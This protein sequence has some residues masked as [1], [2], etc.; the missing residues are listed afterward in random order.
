M[1]V[2]NNLSISY[3]CGFCAVKDLSFSLEGSR[4]LAIVGANGA[5]KSTLLSSFVGITEIK[6]GFVS[7]DNVMVNKENINTIRR[8]AGFVFQ[9]PDDQLFSATVF[10]DI[11]FGLGDEISG[12]EARQKTQAIMDKLNIAHLAQNPPYRLSGG[13]KRMCAIAGVLVMQ[14]DYLLLDEPTAFLD[15]KA[16]RTVINLLNSLSQ[17][18]IIATH[19]LD[20]ALEVCTDVLLLNKGTLA[21]FGECKKLLTDKRLLENIGLELPLCMQ[22]II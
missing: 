3:P 18:K 22:K 16:R 17:T 13:E 6:S 11:A 14:P 21:G 4:S 19:D 1:L 10:D 15:P 9:N 5:G 7:F 8:L 12:D 20:F 2:V